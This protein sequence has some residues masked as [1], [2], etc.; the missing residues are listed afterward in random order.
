MQEEIWNLDEPEGERPPTNKKS[1]GVF[2][3]VLVLFV[4]AGL[5]FFAARWYGVELSIF[6]MLRLL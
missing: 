6:D 5:L 3:L 2:L 1:R 4:I